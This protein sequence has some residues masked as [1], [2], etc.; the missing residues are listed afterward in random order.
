MTKTQKID[1]VARAISNTPFTY[2]VD[3]TY[4]SSIYRFYRRSDWDT[5]AR[6]PEFFEVMG[7]DIIGHT[8]AIAFAEGL[9]LGYAQKRIIIKKNGG[10]E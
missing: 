1:R 10:T 5:A 8:K 2:V 9:A 7:V 3:K 6:T 4:K